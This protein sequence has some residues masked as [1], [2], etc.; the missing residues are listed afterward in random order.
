M[1]NKRAIHIS[2]KF[3]II[4]IFIFKLNAKYLISDFIVVNFC[5]LQLENK[6]YLLLTNLLLENE[7]HVMLKFI[8]F[9]KYINI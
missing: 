4:F 8:K 5:N 3:I 7:K 6:K 1:H 9:I 2:R